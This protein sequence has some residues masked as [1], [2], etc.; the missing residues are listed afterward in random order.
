VPKSQTVNHNSSDKQPSGGKIYSYFF[1]FNNNNL[2]CYFD[3][4]ASIAK[5]EYLGNRKTTKSGMHLKKGKAYISWLIS[6]PYL[7]WE[8]HIFWTKNYNN[9]H[10]NTIQTLHSFLHIQTEQGHE[11]CIAMPTEACAVYMSQLSCTHLGFKL[12]IWSDSMAVTSLPLVEDKDT[13]TL[14]VYD[15]FLQNF[16]PANDTNLN[17][18]YTK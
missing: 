5:I 13:N 17:M 11:H 3:K 14:W 8:C 10:G 12:L 9:P 2:K 15:E 1:H 4:S 16:I 7:P 18:D 6:H